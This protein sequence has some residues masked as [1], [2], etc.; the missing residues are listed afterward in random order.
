MLTKIIA[1]IAYIGMV[2]VNFLATS[3]PINNRSTGAISDAYPNLFAPAGLTFSIWGLI[4]LLLAGYVIYQFTQGGRAKDDLIK[5]NQPP[6]C[7][8]LFG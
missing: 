4:Y 7:R 3:L 6:I 1:V 2:I 5:K 8:H